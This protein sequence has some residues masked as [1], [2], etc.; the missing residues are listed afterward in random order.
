[1]KRTILKKII[2]L[3]L[4][5]PLMPKAQQNITSQ[6]SIALSDSIQLKLTAA[7]VKK[8]QQSQKKLADSIGL[9]QAYPDSIQFNRPAFESRTMESIL[10]NKQYNQILNKKNKPIADAE[11]QAKWEAIV[12]KHEDDLFVKDSVK[13]ATLIP[14]TFLSIIELNDSS[15]LLGIG[16]DNYLYN[17]QIIFY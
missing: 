12:A 15:S 1:M 11:A 10:T 16:T 9:V 8:L 4:L 17:I 14:Q 13:T 3:A 6:L 2:G 7:Q 5:L